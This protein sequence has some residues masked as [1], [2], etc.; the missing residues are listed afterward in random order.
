MDDLAVTI[1]VP[2]YN[3]ASI[4]VEAVRRLLDL[5]PKPDA[6]LIVDQTPVSTPELARWDAEGAI[7]W[8]RLAQPSIPHAMN[9]ALIEATTPLVLFLDDDVVPV[10]DIVS[11]HA[12]GYHDDRVWAAVG[13]CLEPGQSPHHYDGPFDGAGIADLE[14]RFNHDEERR[15][16]NIIAMNLSV[17]RERAL[18]AGGFDENFI[19]VAYRFE[20]ELAARLVN[21]GGT[22]LFQPRARVDHLRIPTGG[23]RSWGEHKTST[24]PMHSVG[25]YY[26]ALS[27]AP[28]FWRYAARR[29][30]R[31]VATA[32]H[33][34]HP[35]AIPGKLIGE[36]RGILLARC[37]ARNGPRLITPPTEAGIEKN[38]RN[39]QPG[40]RV[41]NQGPE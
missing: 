26:F 20:T 6:I 31:N 15:V 41:P 33:L 24:S 2:T 13:Q 17:R 35:W 12:A 19:G 5:D 37:L 16:A 27:H 14:F 3:R 22:I 28:S 29:L 11:A 18:A 32:F 4:A 10:P 38:G 40:L 1:A 23:T 8:I 25:D 39:D 21:A 34:R 9:K 36:T 7:R 30:R